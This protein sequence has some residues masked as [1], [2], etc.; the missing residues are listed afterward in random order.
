MPAKRNSGRRAPSGFCVSYQPTAGGLPAGYGALVWHIMGIE[1]MR[2]RVAAAWLPV[3]LW[4]SVIGQLGTTPRLNVLNALYHWA[5]VLSWT[6]AHRLVGI[7]DS[8]ASE[9]VLR[10]SAHVVVYFVL[11]LFL[12]YA[13]SQT[14][15]LKRKE[16]AQLTLGGGFFVAMYDEFILQAQTAGR[17]PSMGD[18]GYDLVGIGV[19]TLLCC[20]WRRK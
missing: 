3:L 15:P 18:V 16:V 5:S 20:L 14:W 12:F 2:V 1:V 4:V 11:A 10:K 6:P 17:S 13:V 9:H 19:A 8:R 7:L